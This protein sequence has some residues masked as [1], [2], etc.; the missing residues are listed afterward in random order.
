M[1]ITDIK[2][3][4]FADLLSLWEASVRATHDFLSEED[5]GFLRPL[6]RDQAFPNLTLKGVRDENGKILGFLGVA[7]NSV[8]ALFVSPLAFGK[9]IGS[10][11]M[12]YAETELGTTKV[13]VNE[14]N[15]KALG[16]YQRIGY[17]IVGRSP[18][19]GQ[20]KPFPILHLEKTS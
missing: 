9:G 1:A 19:D 18:L 11:L 7:G 6:V 8:E 16:F 12:R 4:E 2:P 3:E 10:K 15:P 13:D 17:E 5:I 14:Q 20:G